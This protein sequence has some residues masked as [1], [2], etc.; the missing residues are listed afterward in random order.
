MRSGV[1]LLRVDQQRVVDRAQGA[2]VKEL[3]E[4]HRCQPGVGGD[5]QEPFHRA[6]ILG[7][8]LADS[9]LIDPDRSRNARACRRSERDVASLRHR[10]Q[11]L[12][13]VPADALLHSLESRGARDGPRFKLDQV[14]QHLE[15]SRADRD[16]F[17][18]ERIRGNAGAS[19]CFSW[20][21][22]MFATFCRRGMFSSSRAPN[23]GIRFAMS[24]S[25]PFS[26]MPSRSFSSTAG[27]TVTRPICESIAASSSSH[28]T[29][30]LRKE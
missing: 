1:D 6:E 12:E 25:G 9:Q 23:S 29:S 22:T 18:R 19:K 10:S 14:A 20:Q 17:A 11:H 7:E 5:D 8:H 13:I 21:R 2:K 24:F 26:E 15:N 28:E 4:Q 3:R 30:P 16:V 27:G